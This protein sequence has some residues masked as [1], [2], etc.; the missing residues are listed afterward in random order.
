M[1]TV[2]TSWFYNW[3][4]E[5][6]KKGRNVYWATAVRR[7]CVLSCVSLCDSLDCGLPGSSACRIYQARILEW[8]AISSSRG[9]FPT[10]GSNSSLTSPLLAGGFF[11]TGATWEAH[12]H[13]RSAHMSSTLI[14]S[15]SYVSSP[16]HTVIARGRTQTWSAEL[17]LLQLASS[18]QHPWEPLVYTRIRAEND[19]FYRRSLLSFSPQSCPQ[20]SL[21]CVFD[22]L[23]LVLSLTLYY[24]QR[25]EQSALKT[26]WY[27][28]SKQFLKFNYLLIADLPIWTLLIL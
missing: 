2:W 4:E 12:Y 18:T 21:I 10:Q 22:F 27:G 25:T 3:W 7:A 23:W 9:I 5:S 14:I 6:E 20:T 11:T 8:V 17:S 26:V 24:F 19:L 15:K 13:T 16:H 28:P 1:H